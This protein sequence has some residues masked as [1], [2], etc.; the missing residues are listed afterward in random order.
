MALELIGSKPVNSIA[1]L[2]KQ[3]LVLV[4]QEHDVSN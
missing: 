4:K 2:M 3:I 1:A